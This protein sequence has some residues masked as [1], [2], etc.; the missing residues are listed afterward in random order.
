M[1]VYQYKCTRD[2]YVRLLVPTKEIPEAAKGLCSGE[3]TFYGELEG[4]LSA[5]DKRIGLDSKKAIE[6]IEQHGFYVGRFDIKTE[7]HTGIKPQK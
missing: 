3:W 1:K 6:E 7:V 5:N 2:S 4:E